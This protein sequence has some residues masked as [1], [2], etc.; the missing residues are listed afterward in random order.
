ME[1]TPG[2]VEGHD[3]ASRARTGDQRALESLVVEHLPALEAYVRAKVGPAVRAR[4]DFADVVQSV[5]VEVLRDGPDFEY[6]GPAA[7]RAWL[8]QHALHKIIN[9]QRFHTRK[10]RDLGKEAEVGASDADSGL[11]LSQ[12]YATLG[13]PSRA[14]MGAEFNARF[15]TAFDELPEEY[16][17]AIALHKFAGLT[18][19]EIAERMDR[20]E[21]AVRN[22]VYRGLARLS[23]ALASET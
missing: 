16:R 10:R 6:Q 18:H 4:E 15:E 14:A 21:G 20:S 1:T 12:V 19:R 5:C 23:K 17:E 11:R 22:L 8:F 7:F 13:T 3:E 9:K 2:D